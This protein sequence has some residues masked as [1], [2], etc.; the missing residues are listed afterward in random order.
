MEGGRRA[1]APVPPPNASPGNGDTDFSAWQAEMRQLFADKRER[2]EKEMN[3]GLEQAADDE[4][5]A[6]YRRRVA[7]LRDLRQ[8]GRPPKRPTGGNGQPARAQSAPAAEISQEQLLT[9]AMGIVEN[10]EA[11]GLKPLLTPKHRAALA[12]AGV[13][14]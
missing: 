11:A 13:T 6:F 8:G 2:F 3:T 12:K 14:V 4:S 7:F 10:A 5:R 1:D 9:D